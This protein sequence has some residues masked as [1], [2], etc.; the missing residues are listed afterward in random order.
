MEELAQNNSIMNEIKEIL[1]TARK[2]VA[3]Q[4]NNE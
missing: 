2:R 1:E 3:V 4:V